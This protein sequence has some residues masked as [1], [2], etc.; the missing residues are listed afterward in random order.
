MA[1]PA[2]PSFKL[3]LS[4]LSQEQDMALMRYLAGK[5]SPAMLMSMF[6]SVEPSAARNGKLI[7]GIHGS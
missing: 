3:E 4:G 5:Y 1:E 7:T 6:D 2:A